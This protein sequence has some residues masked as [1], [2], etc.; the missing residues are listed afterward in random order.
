MTKY[1]QQVTKGLPGIT[2]GSE[3]V[4]GAAGV[5]HKHAPQSLGMAFLNRDGRM[6]EYVEIVADDVETQ[7]IPTLEKYI[8]K[9]LE[10]VRRELCSE[11]HLT[12]EDWLDY[13]DK[14]R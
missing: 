9:H 11:P 1:S 5:M 13:H 3:G 8:I 10:R 14:S 6:L 2:C 7:F 12:P 4:G